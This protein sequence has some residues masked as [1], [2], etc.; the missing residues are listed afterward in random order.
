VDSGYEVVDAISKV[1]TE[2]AGAFADKPVEDVVIES[3]TRLGVD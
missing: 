2:T 1:E 3:V